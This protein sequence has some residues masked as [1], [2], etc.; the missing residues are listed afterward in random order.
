MGGCLGLTIP[1]DG[2]AGSKKGTALGVFTFWNF[3][4]GTEKDRGRP[5]E[6]CGAAGREQRE[7]QRGETLTGCR[8]CAGLCAQGSTLPATLWG[9]EYH[10]PI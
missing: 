7:E 4:G 8:L 10:R 5:R 2:G 9:Q 3:Q 6:L 1:R